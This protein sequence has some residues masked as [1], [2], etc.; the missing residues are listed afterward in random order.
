MTKKLENFATSYMEAIADKRHRNVDWAKSAVRESASITAEK[1]LDLKVID[2]IAQDVP[3]LLRLLDHR[4]VGGRTLATARVEVTPLPMLARER[5][6]QV[7]WRSEMMFIL[8]LVAIYGIVGELSNPGSILPGVAGAIVLVLALYMG[9]VLP[10]NVAGVALI[11]LAVGLLVTDL[12]APTHGVLTAG[13]IIAFFLGSLLLFETREPAFRLSLTVIG[14]ATVITA[15]FFIFVIG[16]GPARPAT[17]GQG[18]SRN[19][20]RQGRA[21]A[22]AHRPGRRQGLRRGR[23][24]ERALRDDGE[25][26]PARA[27]R[28]H[29]RTHPD[30]NPKKLGGTYVQYAKLDQHSR[31]AGFRGRARVHRVAERD[32]HPARRRAR[33]GVSPRQIAVRQGPRPRAAHPHR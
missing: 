10:I 32:P 9:S 5:V 12:F 17:P 14:P 22:D 6:F 1:A 16:A 28:G 20:A 3:D 33:R 24:L 27:D 7:L 4:V 19:H 31:L 8:M 18:R 26:W 13:G 11:L 23:D 29:A 25:T 21:R 30:G 2:L 15:L